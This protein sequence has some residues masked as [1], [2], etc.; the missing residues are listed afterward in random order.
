M[1]KKQI[2][3]ISLLIVCGLALFIV[4][5]IVGMSYQNKKIDSATANLSNV[6]KILSSEVVPSIVSYGEVVKIDNRNIT[7]SFNGDEI[8]VEVIDGASIYGLG[9]D[10]GAG[11]YKMNFNQIKMGDYLNIVLNVDSNGNFTGDSV[12]DFSFSK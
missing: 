4:G 10:V 7:L 8:T 2:I 9:S 5:D 6:F 1:E 11:Q 12:I 3:T